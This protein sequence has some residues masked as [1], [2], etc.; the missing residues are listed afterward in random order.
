MA[1]QVVGKGVFATV[2][3]ELKNGKNVAV[4]VYE[5]KVG[6]LGSD[7]QKMQD[8]HLTNELRLAG[9]LSH[10]NIIAPLEVRI[11]SART[12]LTMEYA[13]HGTLEA[14]V[15]RLGPLGL[16]EAEGRRLFAELVSAVAYLH[17]KAIAHRDIK[18]EN[19]MLDSAWRA[20]VRQLAPRSANHLTGIPYPCYA[21]LDLLIQTSVDRHRALS[22][23]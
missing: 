13:P 15:L 20:R 5:H 22:A 17:G 19:V 3:L 1:A 10:P 4:K 7:A 8:L 2:H 23:H 21:L 18:L 6:A 9:H 14:Y 16:S 12:E 11:G